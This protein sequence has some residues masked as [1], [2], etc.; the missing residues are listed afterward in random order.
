MVQL[1]VPLRY[2]VSAE[3]AASVG[4]TGLT[5]MQSISSAT[6]YVKE[7]SNVFHQRKDLVPRVSQINCSG[8]LLIVEC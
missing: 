5:A 6:S 2:C 8:R 7:G 1:L 4:T 3:D